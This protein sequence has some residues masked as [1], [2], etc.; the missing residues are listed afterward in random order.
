MSDDWK[1]LFDNYGVKRVSPTDKSRS[2]YLPNAAQR[3][4]ISAAGIAPATVRPAPGFDVTLLFEQPPKVVEASFYY[5]Q[6]ASPGRVAEPRMGHEIISS[7]MQ[8]G[9]RVVIGNIEHQLFAAKLHGAAE[10]SLV[11]IQAAAGKA[12]EKTIFERALKAKGKPK[13]KPRIRDDFARNA[14]VVAAASFRAGGICDVPSCVSVPFKTESG[15][16]YLEVHHVIPLG[17]GGNDE[18]ANAAALCPRCHRELH[19]GQ[20]RVDLRTTLLKHI[21]KTY[22]SVTGRRIVVGGG[23]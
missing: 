13:R 4:A 8:V 11:D 9:D 21:A 19:F 18:L 5:S 10:A 12:D 15:T 6:R 20:N 17:E 3:Q 7:W 14:F 1:D 2:A 23:V 16:N 22:D